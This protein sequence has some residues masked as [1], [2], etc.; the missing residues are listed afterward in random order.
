MTERVKGFE[1]FLIDNGLIFEINRKVLHPL[2]L[3]LIVDIS[4]ENRKA[5]KIVGLDETDAAEGFL[6]DEETFE[7]GME[8]LQRFMEKKGLSKIDA[9]KK[10][11]GFII[12][13]K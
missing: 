10:E 2:G 8:K 7:D 1:R 4:F 5:L 12:Q 11:I 3:A 6:F 13:E 9:R